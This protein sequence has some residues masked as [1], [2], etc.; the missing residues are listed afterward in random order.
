M[1]LTEKKNLEISYTNIIYLMTVLLPEEIK[2]KLSDKSQ[3]GHTRSL[4]IILCAIKK[5]TL[6]SKESQRTGSCGDIVNQCHC[7]W[8]AQ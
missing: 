4:Y 2:R 3:T 8:Q 5:R 7:S 6:V 1:L